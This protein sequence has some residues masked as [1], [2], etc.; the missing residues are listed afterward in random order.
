MLD[1]E[2]E[3]AIRARTGA[4]A[5]VGW[6]GMQLGA[7]DDGASEIRLSIRPH[8]LNPGGI[9]HGGVVATLLDA[10]IGL[11]HRTKLGTGRN[12]VT[13]ELH[14]NYIRAAGDGTVL[15]RGRAVSSGERVGYGEGELTDAAGRLLARASATFLIVP[16]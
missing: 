9:L 2:L 16:A 10:A 7:L 3:G 13:L 8:H 11:A 4:S 14:V 15:A 5:F 1:P 12:H 6:M